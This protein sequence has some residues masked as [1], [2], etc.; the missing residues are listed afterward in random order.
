MDLTSIGW[1]TKL[2]HALT[3]LNNPELK[4]ARIFSEDRGS[5]NLMTQ[6]G[7]YVGKVSGNYLYQAHT[8]SDFPAVGDWVAVTYD[9]HSDNAIIH[10]ILPRQSHISRKVSGE[11][12]QEQVIAANIQTVFIVTG[13]DHNYNLRRIER[14]ITLAWNGGAQPVVI[15]NKSDLMSDEQ[16]EGI[17]LEVSDIA[18]GVPVHFICSTQRIGIE[19]ISSYLQEGQTIALL[20]S[21][22]VGKSTLTNF[23]LDTDE[24]KIQETRED[25]SRGRHTT[26]R[27]QLFVLPNGALL[28]DTPGMRELQVWSDEGQHIS[29][30]ED[31]ESLQQDCRF[32]N[33]T[34]TNEAGCAVQKAIDNKELS[35]SRLKN[36]IKMQREQT[37]LESKQNEQAWDSRLKDRQHGKLRHAVLHRNR[38]K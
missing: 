31:I 7:E 25:D 13:L 37:Y 34:H 4:A 15:L 14:Y 24:Q 6:A 3:S 23:L 18:L 1:T 22:G 11:S 5:Y 12:F 26:T 33:C 16:K 10:S 32:R 20:G 30:F 2:N 17:K 9:S 38:C 19:A 21:S 36:Y 35:Y 8:K 27:R 28:M 29:G